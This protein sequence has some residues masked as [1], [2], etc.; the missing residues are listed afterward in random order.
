MI[1]IQVIDDEPSILHAVKRLLRKEDWEVDTY[2]DPQQ[3]LQALTEAPYNLIL[4]DLH[5]PRL[6]GITYLQ[7]ARQ[8]QPDAMRL[9][10]SGR[11]DRGSLVQAI[12]NAQVQRFISKPWD[13]YELLETL[14]NALHVQHLQAEQHRLLMQIQQQQQQLNSHHHT[15][16]EMQR[17]HPQLFQLKLGEDGSILLYEEA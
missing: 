4:C 1:R 12:N 16:L 17:Q 11:G 8:R 13:D 14:R 7:F 5:M 10:F 9:L 6:D 3:A 2:D 15:L